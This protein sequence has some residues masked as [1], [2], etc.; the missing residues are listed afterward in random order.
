MRYGIELGYKS[1]LT[2]RET[3]EGLSIIKENFSD[4]LK[5]HFNLI[6]VEAAVVTDKFSWLNDDYQGTL[7]TIDFDSD[8][9]NLFGEI[10]QANNK[11]RR[12]FLYKNKIKDNNYG[13]LTCSNLI[14]RDAIISNVNSI[15]QTEIG[16]EIIEEKKDIK[17]IQEIMVKIYSIILKIYKNIKKSF[18]ILK[19]ELFSQNLI[20]ISISKLKAL[21]PLLNLNECLSKFSRE[22]GSFVLMSTG[23]NETNKIPNNF[24]QDVFDYSTYMQLFIYSPASENAIELVYLAYTVNHDSLQIQNSKLKENYKTETEY[25]HLITIE[26][27][28]LTISCGLNLARLSMTIL[29]KQHI[30]E[31]QHSVWQKK[32]LDYCE[33]NEI[34]IL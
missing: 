15:V 31:V 10:I 17:K 21:Y 20:F 27:L 18:P 4:E 22:N 19:G 5:K 3:I 12:W 9:G 34:T 29:Q 26:E 24:S 30:G 8:K 33:A 1:K 32:F 2:T 6:S 23:N 16:F 14:Q 13:I 11:W 7:R 25:N 28:P